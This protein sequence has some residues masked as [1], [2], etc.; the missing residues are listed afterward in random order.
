MKNQYMI[1]VKCIDKSDFMQ[2]QFDKHS[3]EYDNT[4]WNVP[5]TFSFQRKIPSF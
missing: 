5:L 1:D 3:T 2:M 4:Q